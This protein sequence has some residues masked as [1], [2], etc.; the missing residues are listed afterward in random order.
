MCL[1]VNSIPV[2]LKNLSQ[3]MRSTH[4]L[5]RSPSRARAAYT[6]TMFLIAET[7]SGHRGGLFGR[8]GIARRENMGGLRALDTLPPTKTATPSKSGLAMGSAGQT[9]KQLPQYMQRSSL[10]VT[11]FSLGFGLIAAVGQE[12]IRVGTSQILGTRSW[13]I[14]GGLRCTPTTAMSEQGTAP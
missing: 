3:P 4:S 7:T 6:S 12:A 2:R 11:L 13:S 1:F 9:V 8:K 5:T 10:M 14:T